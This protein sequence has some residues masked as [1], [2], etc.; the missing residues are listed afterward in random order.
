[1]NAWQSVQLSRH[2]QRPT[3]RDHIERMCDYFFELRGNGNGRDDPAVIIGVATIS[4]HR[5]ALAAVD[6]GRTAEER[7]SRRF[8]MPCPEGF[9]KARRVFDLAERLCLPLLCLVDTPGAYP[10]PQA[11]E[12]GQAQSIS[13]NLE[14]LLTL[15]TPILV[16]FIGEGGSGG[17]LALGIGDTVLIMEHAHFSVI[18]PEG[19]ASILWR[20]ARQAPRAAEFLRMSSRDLLEIGLVDGVIPEPPGGAH[21]DPAASSFILRR[22]II[23]QLDFLESIPVPSLVERRRRRYGEL[24]VEDMDAEFGYVP[25]IAMER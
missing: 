15:S 2:P 19:C 14:R 3:A 24:G 9:G 21:E 17:A 13:R 23:T 20:D 22:E 5:L 16:I 7:K 6:K 4:H 12:N 1:M 25:S 8:G 18:S 10:G 11:E